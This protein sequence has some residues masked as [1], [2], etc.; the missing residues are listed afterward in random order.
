MIAPVRYISQAGEII[1]A[2]LQKS[3]MGAELKNAA[4]EKTSIV[5]KTDEGEDGPPAE[6]ATANMNDV[7]HGGIRVNSRKTF[8]QRVK[9]ITCYMPYLR[10]F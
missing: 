10:G 6:G 4:T 1:Y 9:F 8:C 2:E 5:G 7:E 3:T